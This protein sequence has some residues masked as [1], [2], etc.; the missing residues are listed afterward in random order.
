MSRINVTHEWG[1]LKEV[2]LG[3]HLDETDQIFD[4]QPGMDEEFSFLKRETFDWLKGNA[5]RP[6]KEADPGLFAKINDQVANYVATVE[7][8]GVKVHHF[9]YYEVGKIGGS[10]RCNTCPIFRA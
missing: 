2:I 1:E 6:W 7:K 9:P 4:W 8:L 10:F 5:G 3:R